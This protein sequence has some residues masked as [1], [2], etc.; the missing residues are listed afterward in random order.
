MLSPQ[1]MPFMH[2]FSIPHFMVIALEKTDDPQDEATAA[3]GFVYRWASLTRRLPYCFIASLVELCDQLIPSPRL[4]V[5][6]RDVALINPLLAQPASCFSVLTD[7]LLTNRCGYQIADSVS[8]VL[9]HLASSASPWLLYNLGLETARLCAALLCHTSWPYACRA[10]LIL[11]SDLGG[12]TAFADNPPPPLS[13]YYYFVIYM[14]FV[15]AWGYWSTCCWW[16][17][18]HAVFVESCISLRRFYTPPSN[19]TFTLTRSSQ[20]TTD[21]TCAGFTPPIWSDCWSS[22]TSMGRSSPSAVQLLAAM[23]GGSRILVELTT[24][25]PMKVVAAT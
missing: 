5:L 15:K 3:V 6:L 20:Q 12:L 13:H 25:W 8:L 18:W 2:Y 9:L 1:S 14:C 21:S 16:T 17:Q 24:R 7:V 11:C 19:S 4:I 22:A 23:T 10:L